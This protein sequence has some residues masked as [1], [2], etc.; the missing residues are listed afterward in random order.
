MLPNSTDQ[1]PIDGDTSA[2]QTSPTCGDTQYS[3]LLQK[4]TDR[5][6]PGS[7]GQGDD[8]PSG[9]VIPKEGIS[10]PSGFR[11]WDCHRLQQLFS[12]SAVCSTCKEGKLTIQENF[13]HRQG[14]SSKILLFCDNPICTRPGPVITTT[15]PKDSIT[16]HAPVINHSAVLG[17]RSIG[18][19]HSSAKR[20]SAFMN[21]PPPL[22][23]NSWTEQTSL[24]QG[25]TDDIKEKQLSDAALRLKRTLAT[26]GKVPG[27][28]GDEPDETVKDTLVD[29]AVTVDASWS[30][31]GM[32]APHGIVGVI[33][34]ETRE[35]LDSVTLTRS[36]PE[37]TK[38][39]GKED[40]EGYLEFYENHYP[41]CP[42]NHTGSSGA[43]EAEGSL[44]MYERSV[45]KHKLRYT[46]YVGDGDSKSYTKVKN[47]QPYGPDVTIEKKECIGHVQK[48]MGSRLRKVLDKYKGKPLSDGKQLSGK[49]RLTLARVDYMQVLYGKA[50]RDNID[51]TAEDMSKAVMSILLHYS[52]PA[53]HSLCPPGPNSHCSY[54]RNPATHVP[55]KDPLP[56]AVIDVIRPVFEDLSNPKLLEGCVSSQ[57]QNANEALHSTIWRIIPKEQPHSATE[58]KF[59]TALGIMQFNCGV[60]TTA[61]AV[62]SASGIPYGANSSEL[63]TQITRKRTSRVL[64]ESQPETKER[65]KEHRYKKRRKLDAFHKAEGP[66]YSGGQFH[67][68][69]AQDG[70]TSKQCCRSCGQTDHMR[71]SH[72]NCP[73][74]KRHK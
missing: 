27:L 4:L 68:S 49:N 31:R 10:E 51:K 54:Q 69:D 35:T 8:I 28:N 52:D 70:Q 50:I 2:S 38:W 23:K 1:H 63:F 3:P 47:A 19:G 74:N 7:P 40:T 24:L 25:V 26:Q 34:A 59:G 55:V 30:S 41:E 72:R 65:R 14:W 36:C 56:P 64:H 16:G 62:M 18:Q 11:L 13:S 22:N 45:D 48:R 58:I 20:F 29:V 46:T 12:D 73:K 33:S 66:M 9:P 60:E 57:T 53:D 42:V 17:M 67:G 32:S 6:I 71:S 15:S 39:E 21:L 5:K 43:M 61:K 37:C 44:V